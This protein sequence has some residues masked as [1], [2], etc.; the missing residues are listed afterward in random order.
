MSSSKTFIYGKRASGGGH[1]DVPTLPAVVSYMLDKAGYVAERDLRDVSILEP[2]CGEGEFVVE[3]AKRLQLSAA[4]FGFNA[5][6][7]FSRNVRAY[8]IDAGKVAVCKSRIEELGIFATTRIVAEDFLKA[9]AEKVD[10]VVGNPPYVR[11]ENLPAEM[12]GWFKVSFETFHYRSDLY[13]PFFEKSLSWLKAGGVHCF[14]CSNRWLKGEYGKKLRR[15]ISASYRLQLLIDMEQAV[16]FQEKVSAYPAI[17]L[18]S[19]QSPEKTFE[20]AECRDVALLPRLPVAHKAMPEGEDWSKAFV[21]ALSGIPLLPIEEQGFRIGIGVATGADAVFVSEA[22]PGEVEA[23]LLLPA[24]GGR[25]LKGDCLQWKKKYLLNP[26]ADG[27]GLIDLGRYPKAKRYL[28]AHREKLA[29]RYV[30]RKN[31][32]GWYRTIDRVVPSVLAQPKVLLPDMSGNSYVF[33]D[34]GLYYPLHN[35]YYITGHTVE[36]LRLLA[37]LLMSD[38]VRGQLAAVTNKMNGGFVRW[39]SQH[40]R[41]LRLPGIASLSAEDARSLLDSYARK[42]LAAINAIVSKLLSAPRQNVSGKTEASQNA[43]RAFPL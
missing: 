35:L 40:L 15:Y 39:Q 29:Q 36:H 13:V 3:I 26:Y 11:Y 34:E 19:A 9:R 42:D 17:T 33:V 18:I 25:D 30:A 20:Y 31:P 10:I 27:G 23:E 38:F 24:L 14:L 37:A 16:S 43:L 1:G 4:R 2:S 41:K 8:D 7:A 28:E 6:E 22:L 5:E 21:D 12:L 32:Q